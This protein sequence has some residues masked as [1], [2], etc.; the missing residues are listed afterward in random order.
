MK[1]GKENDRPSAGRAWFGCLCFKTR[2]LMLCPCLLLC[3][4]ARPQANI[5]PMPE[6][7][8]F[9]E[10]SFKL[11]PKGKIGIGCAELKN[12][13][14]Y[15]SDLIF[16]ATGIRLKVIEVKP[17]AGEKNRILL[18]LDPSLEDLGEEGYR[19]ECGPDHI[20]ITARKPAGVFYGI[21]TLR[22]LLPA[23]IESHQP[24]KA[25]PWKIPSVIIEDKPRFRWRGYLMDPARHFITKTDIIRYIDLLALQKINVLQL[26]LTD[27]EGWRLQINS[28]PELAAA[29]SRVP[30]WSGRTGDHWFYSQ[31]DI[32][33]IVTYAASRY[34]T[35]VP[36]IEMPGHSGAATIAYPE[37]GCNNKPSTELCASRESTIAF[38]KNVLGEVI[39][40]FPSPFIHIGG[41]EVKPER[42]RSCA[43]CAPRMK[44]LLGA[45]LPPDVFVFRVPVTNGAGRPFHEDIGRL[46]GEYIRSMDDFISSKGRRMTGWDEILDD[47]LKTNSHAVV[48]AWR[49]GE[50]IAAATSAQYDVVVAVYP[51]YY[52]DIGDIP[53]QRTYEFNP[54]PPS[55][56]AEQQQHVIG[57]QGNMWGENTVSL[58]KIDSFSF[59]RLLA[60][61]ETGWTQQAL[62]NYKDFEARADQFEK[63][64]KLL[65]VPSPVA[66]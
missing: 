42:W 36:E 32:R 28:Y 52:L 27:D 29:G 7:T 37:L 64:L 15:L 50:V 53:L 24:V 62:K 40:L 58:Q 21:Q 55:L 41:D 9:M 8:E 59:P 57:V 66:P 25:G 51:D 2:L 47:G 17:G 22:Q 31:Q 20:A 46:E 49:S 60:I 39:S 16:P 12:T 19:L 6:K 33:E 34:I 11:S 1:M 13:G 56:T 54:L 4:V 30:D 48:M 35:V 38:M 18:K 43:F 63:R 10:G 44:E 65:G 61:A 45:P 5:I 26:H 23:E 14:Q 3:L